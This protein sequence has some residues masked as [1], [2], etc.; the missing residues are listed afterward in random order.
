MAI[1]QRI[2]SV[3]RHRRLTGVVPVGLSPPG[4]INDR[5]QFVVG[6]Q[7]S[8]ERTVVGVIA[9]VITFGFT[10]TG[11]AVTGSALARIGGFVE[12]ARLRSAAFARWMARGRRRKLRHVASFLNVAVVLLCVV[13]GNDVG[14]FN[15]VVAVQVEVF[16][17]PRFVRC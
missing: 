7:Q 6:D 4:I 3:G 2:E 9:R 12:A 17:E 10:P 8:V 16:F 5:K 1:E 14:I 11:L 13:E 15:I